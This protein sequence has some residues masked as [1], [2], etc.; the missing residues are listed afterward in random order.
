MPY[1]LEYVSS[2]AAAAGKARQ[3]RATRVRFVWTARREAMVREVLGKYLGEVEGCGG[4]G[5]GMKWEFYVTGKREEVV[6][7]GAGVMVVEEAGGGEIEKGSGLAVSASLDDGK[8]RNQE[9]GIK[10]R[11]GRPDIH[12][13]VQGFVGQEAVEGRGGKGRVAVFTCGPAGMADSVRMATLS[14]MRAPGH[15]KVEVGYFEEEFG[16]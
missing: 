16:W 2:Q 1:L 14:A 12:E 10:V 13:I 5:E 4:G 6:G 7:G 9:S 11:Y 15:E 3:W 8:A